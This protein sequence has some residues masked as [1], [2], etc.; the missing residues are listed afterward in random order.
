MREQAKR[1]T[2]MQKAAWRDGWLYRGGG[3]KEPEKQ[4]KT[5]RAGGA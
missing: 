2:E 5:R 3:T 4:E 1:G